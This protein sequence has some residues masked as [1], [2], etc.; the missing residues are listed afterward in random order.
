MKDITL[1]AL[2]TL[3]SVDL[4][5]CEDTRTGSQLLRHFDISKPLLSLHDNN[6]LLRLA[7]VKQSLQDGQNLALISENGT[8]LISDPGY[9]LVRD[10]INNGFEV[11][12]IPGP[13]S[14]ITALTLS[15]LPPDK[16]MFVGFLPKKDKAL[17]DV[18][19]KISESWKVQS[20]TL[21]AFES[22]YRVRDTIG[23]IN[24][25]MN[26]PSVV[27]AR[28]LTK[29]Y[30]EVIRGKASEVLTKLT[31]PPKGEIVLLINPN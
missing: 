9:K 16:F 13:S 25:V 20:F 1:R 7:A 10:L 15:G 22:P 8:P 27:V 4:V 6:E 3:K 2:E 12:S 14:V 26:D 18:L 23:V 31:K 21:I 29:T 24:E 11:E 30:Q 19:S 17:R 28:E 5:L